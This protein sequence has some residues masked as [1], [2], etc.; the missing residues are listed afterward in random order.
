MLQFEIDVGAIPAVLANGND[1]PVVI[2]ALKKHLPKSNS[3]PD[4][5]FLGSPETP[6]F[7]VRSDEATSKLT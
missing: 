6:G 1:K 4:R 2:A 7:I 3:E 5:E